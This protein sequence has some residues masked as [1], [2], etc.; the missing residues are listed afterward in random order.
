MSGVIWLI[1]E[2]ETDGETVKVIL[3]K[4]GYPVRVKVLPPTGGAG[5]ISRLLKQLGQLIEVAKQRKQ[6]MDCIAVL[7]DWDSQRQQ[8]RAVYEQ[9]LQIC[10]AQGVKHV[11][12]RDEIESW[13]LADSGLC[14]WLDLTPKNWD[15]QPKPKDTLNSLL[16]AKK[17]MKYQ[18]AH[19]AKVIAQL[20][21]DGDRYSPSLRNALAHLDNAPCTQMDN[22]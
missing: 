13:M 22:E 9:I 8:D 19:R 4:R 7:H 21:G 2:D 6:Q 20:Q 14:A 10:A 16:Q 18:G 1:V 3:R 12:A 17:K 15:E 11:F 5:G